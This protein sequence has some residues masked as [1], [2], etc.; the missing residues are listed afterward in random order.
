M[1]KIYFDLV[2]GA[3][4][5]MLLASMIDLGVPVDYLNE[6]FARMPL[7][8]IILNTKKVKRNGI[9]CIYLDP[10][11]ELSCSYEY[12]HQ[13]IDIIKKGSFSQ[14]VFDRCV[15]VLDRLAT[16]ESH[17]QGIAKEEV[18]FND[19]GPVDTIVE[20]VGVS[21]AL[22]YL[23]IEK[24]EFSTITD[25]HGTTKTLHGVVPVPV[26]ATTFMIQGFDISI[27][28][29][30]TELVTPTGAALLTAL[31][32]QV[33]QMKGNVKKTGYS[34]G[35]KVFDHHPN[36]LR[37]FLLEENSPIFNDEV[38]LI[39][40]DMDHISGEVMGHVAG[41]L[42]E[43]GAL[44][45]SWIPVFMKKG[46]PAY[47]ISVISKIDIYQQ[48]VD[49]I[50]TNTHTL[51]VRVQKVQRIIASRG[52]KSIRFLDQNVS[53]KQCVYKGYTFSKLEYEA[54]AALSKEKKMPLIDIAEEYVYQKLRDR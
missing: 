51:G 2:S 9:Q 29:I 48:L 25:G 1:V 18:H 24:I 28:D 35:T 32:S 12:L 23:G 10:H 33:K 26:P 39:E 16:A 36:I 4:G 40:S 37:S 22:E 19:I 17:L 30:P 45:V 34:C 43:N 38:Y 8:H 49:L 14:K 46:R 27:L 53:E 52:Q 47:R 42:F 41:L 50:I 15:K 13:I 3:S 20:I 11:R 6:Q 31:G 44:D 21:C 5:H 7:E 54:L